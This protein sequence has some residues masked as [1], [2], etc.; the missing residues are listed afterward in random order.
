KGVRGTVDGSRYSVGRPEWIEEQG[1]SFPDSLR[2]SLDKA[3]ARGESVIALMDESSALAVVGLADRVRQSAKD[4]VRAL[5]E[6]GVEP[7]MITGDAEA[8]AKTVAA[9][10]GIERY[11][12]R[13][14]P[15]EKAEKI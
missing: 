11:Y 12:A 8:V 7:V 9:E 1:L 10:L 2:R 14:L 4:T 13:V 6:A 3:E 5:K 15:A